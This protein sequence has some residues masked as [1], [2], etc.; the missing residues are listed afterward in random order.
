MLAGLDTPERDNR[1]LGSR[2]CAHTSRPSVDSI[3][4]AIS[5]LLEAQE[6]ESGEG[7]KLELEWIFGGGWESDANLKFNFRTLRCCLPGVMH[8]RGESMRFACRHTAR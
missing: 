2:T 4:H 1:V 6:G 5:S 8:F 3:R 7:K